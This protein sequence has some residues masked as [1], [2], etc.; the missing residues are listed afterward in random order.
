[1]STKRYRLLTLVALGLVAA[2]AFGVFRASAPA[3]AQTP[4]DTSATE[5]VLAPGGDVQLPDGTRLAFTEVVEDSR[6]PMDVMCIWQGQPVLAFNLQTAKG[7]SSDFEI[8]YQGQPANKSVEGYVI[9][10]TSVQPHP[11]SSQSIDPSDYRVT[12]SIGTGIEVDERIITEADFGGTVEVEVGQRV[13]VDPSGDYIWTAT[14]DDPEVLEP[15]PQILIYPPPPPAFEGVA[16]GATTLRITQQH[17]CR[18]ASP[19][20]ML[21][22][23]TF[24]VQVIVR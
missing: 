22:D 19:P 23:Q 8:A 1:M 18:D 4:S 9:T 2:A 17:P 14:V 6:C 3:T 24:D 13:V 16:P 10:V 21:P 20:C 12:V 11:R 15:L 5:T 7:G